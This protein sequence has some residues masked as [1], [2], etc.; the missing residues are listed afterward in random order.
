[1]KH[2]SE[3]TDTPMF[4]AEL[5]TIASTQKQPRYPT[6]DEWIKK[7]WYIYTMEFC[8]D[9]KKNKC[10]SIE[11]R[12]MNLEPIIQSEVTQKEK[13][14]HCVLTHTYVVQKNDTDE[15]ICRAGIETQMQR[16][17]SQPQQGKERV[18]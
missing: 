12:Q 18:G 5:F 4:I 6:A 13:D 3:D 7:L 9:I 17:D 2:N 14:K 8:Q 16:M 1:M 11:L 15:P 10:E